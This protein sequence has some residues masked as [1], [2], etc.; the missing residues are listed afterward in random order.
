MEQ[1]PWARATVREEAW[2]RGEA[3][4]GEE[5]EGHSPPGPGA[6]AYARVAGIAFRMLQESP[7]IRKNVRNAVRS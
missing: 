7:A 6:T 2:V 1:D 5:W 3:R 4:A